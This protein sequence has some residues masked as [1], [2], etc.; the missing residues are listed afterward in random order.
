MKIIKEGRLPEQRRCV[1]KGKCFHCWCVV[2]VNEE[3]IDSYHRGLALV[4]CPT[5]GCNSDILVMPKWRD[6]SNES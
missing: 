4:T 1:Y 5:R 6:E 2:E 3:E